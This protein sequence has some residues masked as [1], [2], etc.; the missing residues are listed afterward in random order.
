MPEPV[1]EQI[2]KLRRR[3]RRAACCEQCA[4]QPLWRKHPK[5]MH[6]A[7]AGAVATVAIAWRS[8]PSARAETR[9]LGGKAR[10]SRCGCRRSGRNVHTV[11]SS[12]AA[13]AC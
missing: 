10:A 7:L 4:G 3:W 13:N 6:T 11:W 9:F 1:R 8:N 2:G 5:R 12:G